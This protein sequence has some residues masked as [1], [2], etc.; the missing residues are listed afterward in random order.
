MKIS[1]LKPDT[2]ALKKM[3]C[4]IIIIII[5]RKRVNV[6]G[7]SCV[8]VKRGD[9]SSQRDP[10]RRHRAELRCHKGNPGILFPVGVKSGAVVSITF[11]ETIL[12][13]YSVFHFL[14]VTLDSRKSICRDQT[15][16]VV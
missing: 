3:L 2:L 11:S 4:V 16:R 13:I 5:Y 10:C 15:S 12:H 1:I 14:Y 8:V 7:R 9:I 6:K